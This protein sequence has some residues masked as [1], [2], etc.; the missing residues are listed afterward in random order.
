MGIRFACHVC[1]RRLNIKKELAG[2]RGICPVCAARIRI[3]LADTDKSTPVDEKPLPAAATQSAAA[4]SPNTSEAQ[5]PV[6]SPA[7]TPPEPS[8]M[9]DGESDSLDFLTE[10][11]EATWYV[12]PPSGGQYGPATSEVL[13][14][15]IEEG[16][17]AATALLWREG[18]PQWRDASEALPEYAGKLPESR[19]GSPNF[20]QTSRA[21]V[22]PVETPP[23]PG[24]ASS[25]QLRGDSKLG[26]IRGSRSNRRIKLIAVLVAI[27]LALALTFVVL[28]MLGLLVD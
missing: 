9:P 10:E 3:P 7:E 19:N 12:R 18:W 15:W 20:G 14:Q 5:Q 17:V 28:S 2:K 21:V 22:D 13:K 25:S 27:V 23:Q 6:S 4:S 16:R 24:S 8:A 11:G 1:E 26:S